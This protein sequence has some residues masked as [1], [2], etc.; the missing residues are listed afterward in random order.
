M[1]RMEDVGHPEISPD[2]KRVAYTVTSVDR[3][4][5]KRLTSIW[6]VDW[7]GAEDNYGNTSSYRAGKRF[8]WNGLQTDYLRDCTVNC[9]AAGM[10]FP[11]FA[12]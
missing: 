5:D 10:L 3:E 12:G 11:S 4:A 1:Y 2:G 8:G 7:K 6:M 9:G